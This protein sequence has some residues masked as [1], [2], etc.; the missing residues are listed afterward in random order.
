[1]YTGW[2][3]K[4][5]RTFARNMD[6]AAVGATD[7]ALLKRGPEFKA[8]KGNLKRE[9]A[10]F[11]TSQNLAPSL[12]QA[13]VVA[14]HPG[15]H[16]DD[17][18]FT[19]IELMIVVAVIAIILT[20]AIPAYYDYQIRVKIGEG[21]SV[22]AAA[23]AAAGSVCQEDLTLVGLDNVAAGYTFDGATPFVLDIVISGQC[24]Q[25]IVTIY[26]QNTGAPGP[27]PEITLTGEFL[28]G[29]GRISW[30]CTSP[31]TANQFLPSRCRS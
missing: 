11:T 3:R 24:S 30:E 10:M 12:N 18:G 6:V 26:T 29:Y 22:A 25:P 9:Y 17:L 7:A 27:A 14:H 23:K 28:D 21:L 5:K 13:P 4:G 16:P 1:M 20:M 15:K 31:N 2:H 8:G 19:L